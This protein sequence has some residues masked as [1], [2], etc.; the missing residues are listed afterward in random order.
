VNATTVEQAL[1]YIDLGWRTIPIPLGKKIPVIDAWQKLNIG[2][3]EVPRYFGER[4]NI[5][6]VLGDVSGGLVDIDLDSPAAVALAPLFLPET[7]AFGRASKPRSHFLYLAR[8]MR[9]EKFTALDGSMLVEIRANKTAGDGE[10]LQTVF[11]ESIH[12]SGEIVEWDTEYDQSTPTSIGSEDLRRCVARLAS[13]ALLVAIG[14]PHDRAVA[15]GQSP[16]IDKLTGVEEKG[17]QRIARWLGLTAAPVRPPL[18][19]VPSLDR[20]RVMKRAR[21]YMARVPGAVSGSGGHQQTWEG[22][23]NCIRGFDL[24]LSEAHE[25]LD[26]Y[27][28]RCD[29]PW[30]EREIEHKLDGIMK[31]DRVGR[32]WLLEDRNRTAPPRPTSNAAP[33]GADEPGHASPKDS[34][35]PPKAEVID[36]FPTR[37][38]GSVPDEGPTKW[39]VRDLWLDQG[40]GIIGGEPKSYKSFAAAQLATCVASGKPMFSRYEVAQGRVLMFNAE[41]RPTMTRNRV[42]QMARALDVDFASL[43]LHLIDVPALRLD[44]AEQVERLSRTVAYLRPALLIL[45]PMRDLHGLDENDA[46]IVSALLAPLRILQRAYACAVLLVHHMA[47]VTESPRRAGQRLRGSSAL[48]GWVDSALYLT[49]KDGGIVVTPEHRAAAAPEPFAFKLEQ[50]NTERGPALWLDAQAAND[51]ERQ[52]RS[53]AM[54]VAENRVLAAV[55]ASNEPLTLR[56]L[57]SRIKQRAGKTDDAVRSLV[58]RGILIEEPVV[59][60]NNQAIPGFRVRK[61]GV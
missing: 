10:G 39:L 38:I 56:D 47:K 50:T 9:T 36:L 53:E 8:F 59:K 3:D 30:T 29:P 32:G 58:E 21:E 14:W 11:P 35:P 19:S 37:I 60:G 26:E 18:R 7:M 41:D 40:V 16:A 31:A 4:C 27:N 51:E 6:V 2:R 34:V 15:F 61:G 54:E 25:I 55:L 33:H 1:A 24:T 45:D 57:R 46:Q 28:R 44:D 48:H 20:E 13:A 43:D 22:A 52:E 23:I 49:H 5:G 12:P 42:A 17:V